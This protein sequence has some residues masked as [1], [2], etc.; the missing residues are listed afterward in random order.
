VSAAVR[1]AAGHEGYA[2]A[3][4][5][6]VDPED[7]AAGEPSSIA[8]EVLSATRRGSIVVLHAA[9]LTASALPAIIDG[10]RSRGLRSVSL[11]ELL[12]AGR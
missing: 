4:L 9:R 11:T 6:D 5:W 1:A 7:W 12:A 10:L 2:Y 8:S 3:V